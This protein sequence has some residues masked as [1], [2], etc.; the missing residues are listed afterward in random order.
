VRRGHSRAAQEG[1]FCEHALLSSRPR[2]SFT[3]SA[4]PKAV[5]P[6]TLQAP[7]GCPP[8]CLPISLSVCSLGSTA[9]R[10]L[11]TGLRG[12]V[13]RRAQGCYSHSLAEYAITACSWF[14]KDLRRMRLAQRDRR[15]APFDVEE[16]RCGWTDP[17]TAH[18]D[19]Q[20]WAAQNNCRRGAAL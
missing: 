20:G 3:L 15:W 1:D 14:A 10:D 12:M 2:R 13:L 19:R 7:I 8:A 4:T 11:G 18:A 5:G 6:S 9:A 17:A 16:L